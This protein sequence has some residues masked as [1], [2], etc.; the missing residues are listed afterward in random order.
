MPGTVFAVTDFIGTEAPMAWPGIDRR[1]DTAHDAAAATE[2]C[3]RRLR[4]A[5]PVQPYPDTVRG[6]LGDY[7]SAP[8]VVAYPRNEAEIVE[9][10]RSRWSRT[11]RGPPA[12]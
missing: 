9:V 12:A 6:L 10:R 11:R 8:D 2:R 4:A 1:L 7:A 3:E 5:R